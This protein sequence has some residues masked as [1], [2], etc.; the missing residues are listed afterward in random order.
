MTTFFLSAAQ[1]AALAALTHAG[2]KDKVT[3]ILGAVQLTV[4]PATVTATATD[5]YMAAILTFPLGDTAHT[6]PDDG[7]TL[8]INGADLIALAKE[9]AG[10]MLTV[11]GEPD[12]HTAA[13]IT[14]E[15]DAYG[16]TRVFHTATGN[17]PPVARLFPD[18][19]PDDLPGGVMLK[20]SL[21][22]RL[23]KLTLPGERPV[24]A[25]DS[26]W[27]LTYSAPADSYSRGKNGPVLA[28][29][30]GRADRD[31]AAPS[32]RVLVQ[33]NIRTAH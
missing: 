19:T 15:G 5:R 2:S 21:L 1:L 11:D 6:L 32:L 14:A 12:A 31:T 25:A 24:T 9:K 10:F 3:P 27:A 30:E 16:V 4:T 7:V 8:T 29:R 13:A 20:M 33:P 17:Y 28:S 26:P 18:E 22:G 23:A